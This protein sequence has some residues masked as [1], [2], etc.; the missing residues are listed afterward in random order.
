MHRTERRLGE[1]HRQL[2]K[3]DW[4]AERHK[5]AS[6]SYTNSLSLLYGA[7]HVMEE[8]LKVS[9]DEKSRKSVASNHSILDRRFDSGVCLIPIFV[10]N[11]ICGSNENQIGDR[12]GRHQGS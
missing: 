1:L 6:T 12:F 2:D 9:G 5:K 7:K 8:Y 10:Q 3:L 4:D 11:C